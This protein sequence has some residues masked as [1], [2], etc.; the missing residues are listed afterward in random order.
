[1]NGSPS[2]GS[3]SFPKLNGSPS[4]RQPFGVSSS[5][6]FLG[7]FMANHSGFNTP[8]G[9]PNMMQSHVSIEHKLNKYST[10]SLV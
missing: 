10:Y 3:F 5:S 9:G 2:Y 7:G 8:N 1:M 4:S 6:G